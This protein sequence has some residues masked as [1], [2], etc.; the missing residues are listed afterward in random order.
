MVKFAFKVE[1]ILE[2]RAKRFYG[3]R[4]TKPIYKLQILSLNSIK[5]LEINQLL[6]RAL[7]YA[8]PIWSPAFNYH[9][10]Y[11]TFHSPKYW[12]Y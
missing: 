4:S 3:Y 2:W 9:K 12:T 8:I 11:I 10:Y 1:Y 7:R 5:S 6:P